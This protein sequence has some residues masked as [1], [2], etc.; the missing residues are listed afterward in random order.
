MAIGREFFQRDDLR[1]LFVRH[2]QDILRGEAVHRRRHLLV[3]ETT[4]DVLDEILGVELVVLVH[5]RHQL[6]LPSFRRAFAELVPGVRRLLGT[7]GTIGTVGTLILVLV[8]AVVDVVAAVVD[9]TRRRRRER[10]A[11][12]LKRRA[13]LRRAAILLRGVAHQL[14]NLLVEVSEFGFLQRLPVLAQHRA[15]V[16]LVPVHRRHH[17]VGGHT[18]TGSTPHGPRFAAATA[19][20]PANPPTDAI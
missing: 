12:F 5:L 15:V 16:V 20:A 4:R 8:R 13:L 2:G 7:V 14:A 1:Q 10:R 9:A 3:L 17:L 18:D 11:N 6:L 19:S